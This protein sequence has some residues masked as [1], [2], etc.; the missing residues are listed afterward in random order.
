MLSINTK[1]ARLPLHTRE[2][3]EERSSCLGASAGAEKLS[4]LQQ[5]QREDGLGERKGP[6]PS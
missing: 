3:E 1:Y 4:G 6:I 2:G 5:G